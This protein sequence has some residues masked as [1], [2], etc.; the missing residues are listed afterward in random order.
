MIQ[1]PILFLTISFISFTFDANAQDRHVH[2][3]GEHLSDEEILLAD[4]LWGETLPSAFYWLN[5]NSGEWGYEDNPLVMGVLAFSQQDN[6]HPS[7]EQNRSTRPIIN[8]EPTGS[9]V[10]GEK[11]SYASVGGT[12]VRLCD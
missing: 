7:Q 3:N 6:G 10:I 8:N 12:S 2:I 9:V 11:C 1:K 4:Q 5:P